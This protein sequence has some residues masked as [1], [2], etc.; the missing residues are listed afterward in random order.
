MSFAPYLRRAISSSGEMPSGED[1][2]DSSL[3]ITGLEFT[4][5]FMVVAS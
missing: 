4:N 3:E 5:G 2:V 1:G